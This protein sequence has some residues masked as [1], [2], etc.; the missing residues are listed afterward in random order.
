MPKSVAPFLRRRTAISRRTA[1]LGRVF[2][3]T[4]ETWR[5]TQ[6]PQVVAPSSDPV[7][8]R[9]TASEAADL[10]RDAAQ[11]LPRHG[12]H[13]PSGAWWGADQTF[14]HRFVVHAGR[15]RSAAGLLALSGLLGLI[16]LRLLRVGRSERAERAEPAPQTR[17]AIRPEA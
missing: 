6:D 12:F 8:S 11:A 2:N 17:G 7:A 15:R 10:A 13:K 4:R 9:R 5:L 3:V 1:A 14:F 16:A